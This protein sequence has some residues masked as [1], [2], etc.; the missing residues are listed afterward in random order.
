MSELGIAVL[1]TCLALILAPLLSG[2]INRVKAVVAGRRGQPLLQTYYDIAKL[3]SKS[4]VYSRTTTW[5]FRAGPLVGLATGITALCMLP[6]GGGQAIASFDGDFILFVGLLGLGRFFTIV[7][8]LDTGSAF[9]GM[10]ASREAWFSAL[11][12][13]ALILALAALA[14]VTGKLSLSALLSGLGAGNLGGPAVFLAASATY[15]VFL[16]ENARMPVDDPTTH[17]ELTMIHEVMV[18][19]H[20][21]VDFAAITYGASVKLWVLGGLFAAILVPKTGLWWL[22][23]LDGLAALFAVGILTGIVESIMARVRLSRVPQLLVAGI[24]MAALGLA[25]AMVR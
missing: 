2:I 19:D 6:W 11:T 3:L 20:A 7:A 8:A 9:E 4:A 17:L 16:A 24:A 5:L 21:G 23:L 14:H 25:L 13:P 12:E 1:Q 10:G 15:I 18:L 22:D